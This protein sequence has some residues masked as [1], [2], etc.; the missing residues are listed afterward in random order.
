[1][2]ITR[3]LLVAT[4]LASSGLAI[5][6]S[7]V[8]LSVK[9]TITPSACEANLSNGGQFDLG[10]IAAKDLYKDQPTELTEQS[11]QL[12][13]TCEAATLVAIESKDNRAGSSFL[14]AANSFGLGVINDTQKLG[15]L[16][17]AIRSLK[18]DGETAY[19]IHSMNGGLTWSSGGYLRPGNLISAYKAAPVAPVPL[20]TLIST[21]VISPYIAPANSLTLTNEVPIDGSVTLTVRY[22]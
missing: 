12:T 9:G 22:L 21:M 20:Q 6:A 4:L 16:Y 15:H 3:N 13:V 14:D 5:A 1:M 19:G 10:K 2:S 7:S 11:T 18:A 17:V 8:D